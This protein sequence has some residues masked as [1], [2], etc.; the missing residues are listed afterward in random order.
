MFQNKQKVALYLKFKYSELWRDMD[1]FQRYGKV[2]VQTALMDVHSDIAE[3]QFL[4]LMKAW[5]K[6]GNAIL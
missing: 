3:Y 1:K 2:A 4:H 6:R 5:E